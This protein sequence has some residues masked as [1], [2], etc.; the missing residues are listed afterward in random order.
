[1]I[2]DR[3]ILCVA[4]L[5]MH[6]YGNDAETEAANRV[7]LM[8]GSGDWHALLTWARIRRTIAALDSAPLGLPN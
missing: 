6:E 5:M 3:E 4:H 8:R 1:M 7:D 2:S